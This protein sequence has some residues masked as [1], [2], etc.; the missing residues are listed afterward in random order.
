MCEM[1]DE[2]ASDFH[3]GGLS[4]LFLRESKEQKDS[5]FVILNNVSQQSGLNSSG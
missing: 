1:A 5:H 4:R 2:R 3:G